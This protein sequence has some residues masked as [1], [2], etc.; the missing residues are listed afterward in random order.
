MNSEI[1][2]VVEQ[3]TRALEALH[4]PQST[5]SIR[6]QSQD[7][8][9]EVKK[10][11]A[12]YSYALAIIPHSN[13]IVK[14]YGL[15]IIENLVKNQWVNASDSEKDAVKNEMLAIFIKEKL[16][17]V[18]VEIVKRDWPQRWSGLLDSLVTISKIGEPQTE[19]VLLTFGKLPHEIIFDSS[20]T[21]M[22]ALS[23][24]R[25]KDLMNGI[26]MAITSLMDF[27]Y[28][29]L[30]DRYKAYKSNPTNS[31]NNNTISVLLNALLSYIDWIPIKLIQDHKLDFIYSQLLQE[32][33]FR[34]VACD[35]LLLFLSR[36]GKSDEK[37]ELL[38]PFNMLDRFM[39]AMAPTSSGFEKDYSFH[40]RVAQTLTILGTTHLSI[41]VKEP[42]PNNYNT[43]LQLMLQMVAHPS[44]L[45]T[46]L[47]MPFWAA[48]LKNQE[49]LKMPHIEALFKELLQTSQVKILKI[50]EP[51]DAPEPSVQAKY[52]NIDFGTS[53]EW[54]QFFATIRNRFIDLVKS[55]TGIR[56]DLVFQ[57]STQ[58]VF[59]VL[60]NLQ[61][62][63]TALT[64]EQ[65]LMLESISYMMDVVVTQ[66]PATF[67]AKDTTHL[68]ST[69]TA[70][71]LLTRL[72][73]MTLLDANATSFQIDCIKPFTAYY[74]NHPD[75]IQF[76]LTKLVPLIPFKSPLDVEGARLTPSTTHA[77]RRIITCLIN[78]A[79]ALTLPMMPFLPHLYQSVGAL[80][81]QN[82]VTETE[83]VM[84]FHLLIIFCNELP[85]FDQA[86]TFLREL[87][88]PVVT[89]WTSQ[90]MTEALKSP[91]S[92]ATYLGLYQAESQSDPAILKRRK[93][94]NYIVASIQ[95]FWKKSKL[96]ATLPPNDEGYLPFIANGISYPSKLP[97]SAF[98]KE[99]L[100]N[101]VS[102]IRTMHQFWNPAFIATL[103]PTYLPIFKLDEAITAPLLGQ[104]YHKVNKTESENIKFLRNLLDLLRDACYE[105]IG[106]G[107]THSDELFAIPTLPNILYDSIFSFL[108]Y[109]ENRHLKLMIRQVLI[110]MIKNTP[111]K[112]Q[113]S[114]FD[115][116]VPPFLTILFNKIKGGWEEINARSQKESHDDDEIL[117]II[118]DKI[119]RDLT[120]EFTMWVKD[121][122]GSQYLLTNENIVKPMVY[123]L[124]ACLMCTD[125]V[126]A[127]KTITI[128]VDLVEAIAH[129]RRYNQLLAEI[130]SISLRVLVSNKIPDLLPEFIGL[131]R[132]IYMRI[133]KQTESAHQVLLMLNNVT[134]GMLQKL[135]SDLAAS[136]TEKH[137]KN[138]F[139]AM[140]SDA[141]GTNIQK[142]K[143]QSILDLPEK[144]FVAKYKDMVSINIPEYPGL[145]S[146]NL[147]NVCYSTYGAKDE[148]CPR[149]RY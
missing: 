122:T 79:S 33:P 103:Q 115:P 148:V 61:S 87:M 62:A 3:I 133:H 138:L 24:Q 26:N 136:K 111:A 129:D 35:S 84:L 99:V 23:D 53:R 98:V 55:M 19:L 44:V 124:A 22:S 60:P 114:I 143:K 73:D 11:P 107:F 32:L 9:E 8:L 5:A 142:L 128:C 147:L 43:Y 59:E 13:E 117:E 130:L 71:Q 64:H 80:F 82:L 101:V 89:S 34:M 2:A 81:T 37:A 93:H 85:S 17:T 42:L 20:S 112:L 137:Q 125:S 105:I 28:A 29:L 30:E 58:K 92:L 31:V 97:I 91:E 104:D 72:L 140:L 7:F 94:L 146:A 12:A 15:H 102:L 47:S 4:N 113:S 51:T 48:F 96:P 16:V 68:E 78:L 120:L 83:R 149:D 10:R 75:S 86:S 52:S 88:A 56:P 116:L 131:I 141:I 67:F 65:T 132:C 39:A 14:H 135:D 25:K 134:P 139:K 144:L 21:N 49:I 36:K 121:F 45:L 90:E 38:T 77:R 50:G 118:D 70:K 110:F 57:F 6:Q 126:I 74:L 76:L 123:G 108:E 66:L 41:Y 100:P 63:T 46:S 18:I 27:F 119:L 106:Y 69:E 1:G 127:T 40:K 145:I 109:A 95:I 54:S